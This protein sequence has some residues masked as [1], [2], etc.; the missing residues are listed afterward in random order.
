MARQLMWIIWPGFFMAIPGVGVVFSLFDP[1]DML[2]FGAPVEVSRLGV[3]TLGFLL[4][5][6][7]G[8][9]CSAMTCLLQRTPPE[10]NRDID[11]AVDS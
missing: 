1:E 5:W 2:F 7:F 3:Y 8:A 6:L 11:G 10:A 9:S 4:I